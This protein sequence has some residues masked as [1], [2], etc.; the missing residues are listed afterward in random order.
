MYITKIISTVHAHMHSHLKLYLAS[1]IARNDYMTGIPV[2]SLQEVTRP[3]HG[4]DDSGHLLHLPSSF[5][6]VGV[7]INGL[8]KPLS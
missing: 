5:S 7:F 8:A 3:V 1:I 6:A 2:I 4:P